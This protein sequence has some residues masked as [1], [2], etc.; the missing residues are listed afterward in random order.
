MYMYVYIKI[1]VHISILI[2][3]AATDKMLELVSKRTFNF[4]MEVNYVYTYFNM[5]VYNK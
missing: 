1:Y 3:D 4:L 2:V 5:Y